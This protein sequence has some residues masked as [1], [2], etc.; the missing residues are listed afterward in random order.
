MTTKDLLNQSLD[1]FFSSNDPNIGG[2]G[3]N[4]E[5]KTKTQLIDEL[6]SLVIAPRIRLE[7]L[8]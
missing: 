1:R 2:H 8:V 6:K 5:Y 7:S 4:D 3:M